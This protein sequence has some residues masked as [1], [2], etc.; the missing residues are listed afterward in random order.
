V[1]FPLNSPELLVLA[2]VAG[3]HQSK[4]HSMLEKYQQENALNCDISGTP[5]AGWK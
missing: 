5:W 3:R 1:G 2:S 4:F